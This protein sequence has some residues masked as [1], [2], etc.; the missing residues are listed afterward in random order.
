MLPVRSRAGRQAQRG[1]SGEGLAGTM[2]SGQ[3]NPEKGLDAPLRWR[4]PRHV[5]VMSDLFHEQ[6]PFEFIAQVW[7]VMHDA[8]AKIGHVFQILTK[9]PER[10]LEALGPRGFGWY[11]VERPVLHPEPGIWLGVSVEDQQRADER[12]PLL[13]QTPAAVRF[14]SCEPLLSPV[15]LSPWF[16]L[17]KVDGAWEMVPGLQRLVPDLVIVGGESGPRARPCDLGWLR[18]IVEQCK[19]AGVPCFV[20][21]LGR[22]VRDTQ[23]PTLEDAVLSVISIKHP[24]GSNPSEWPKDLRVRE[25]PQ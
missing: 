23:A 9:R 18:S 7:E 8:H 4:R 10:M 21:Q 17:H 24:K 1:A 12:I 14:L 20:K 16:P 11:A 13:L 19:A 15:D 5:E 22:D 3:W 25:W 6:V 2:R